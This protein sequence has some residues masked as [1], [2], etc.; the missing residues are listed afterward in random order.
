MT[1]VKD[2]LIFVNSGADKPYNQYAAYVIAFVAKQVKKID[3]VTV[4]Y[5]PQGVSM[6]KKGE[7]AKFAIQSSVKELLSGQIDGLS[8]SDLPDNLEQLAIF[9]SSKLGVT[10]ASCGTFHVIDGFASNI[11]DKS[12]VEDFIIPL[13]VPKAVE[14]LLKADK[15]H[16]M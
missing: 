15:V 2:L 9:L 3:N 10:I 5:G 11:D 8:A 16:Y 1:E 4:Y 14:A 6:S 7:L 12:N 13:E